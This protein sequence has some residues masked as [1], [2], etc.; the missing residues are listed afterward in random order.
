M[1]RDWIQHGGRGR[2]TVFYVSLVLLLGLAV[3]LGIAIGSTEIPPGTVVR[4]LAAKLLP[5]SLI[6][7]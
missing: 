3:V 6:H 5:L 2:L 1:L 4:V 7:I